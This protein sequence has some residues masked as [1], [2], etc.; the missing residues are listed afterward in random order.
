MRERSRMNG[1]MQSGSRIVGNIALTVRL[2]LITIL[3]DRRC[4]AVLA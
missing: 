3:L 4:L 2:F 1:R